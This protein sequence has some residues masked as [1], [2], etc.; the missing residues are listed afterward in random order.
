MAQRTVDV[1]KANSTAVTKKEEPKSMMAWIKG[2][3]KQ[4][5]KALPSVMTPERFA[6]IAMTAVTQNP[7]LGAC[8]PGSFIGALL[9]AAQLGLEPNTPLGQA[10]L[11]PFKNKG[12]LEAQFQLGYRGL[13]ELAYRSGDLKSI[14]AHIVYENDTFE[15]ELGL[16]PKLRHVPAMKNRGGIAWVYAICKLQSGGQGFEVMSFEDVEEHK[17]K[18]S[19]AASKGFSPWQTSWEEMAKK[20]VIKKVLKYAPLRTE[21][22]RAVGD[23]ESSFNFTADGD[24]Y[25]IIQDRSSVYD[26]SNI[27]DVSDEDVQVQEEAGYGEKEAA[28][29]K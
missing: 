5:A 25:N 26:E 22:A 10:Y 7:T 20:T 3:E 16:E 1:N 2:Y 11:I 28:D 8:T 12:V 14:D 21:F 13:I 9:T 4:I 15:Y 29:K 24:D 18:Y 17:K 19:K 6:R 27:V 23:D